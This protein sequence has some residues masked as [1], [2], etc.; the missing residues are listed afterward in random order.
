MQQH[1]H[2]PTIANII[3]PYP[4]LKTLP[5]WCGNNN[6]HKSNPDYHLENCCLTH[7]VG[8]PIHPYH[9]EMG[10][11]EYQIEFFNEFDQY[12]TEQK[13]QGKARLIHLNKGRQMGFTELVLRIIQ[14]YCFHDYAGK[15]IGIQAGTNGALARF[16]L[17]RFTKLFENIPETLTRKLRGN[18]LEL[19]NGTTITAY[20]ASE[21]A[22]TGF[23]NFG[24]LFMDEAAKWSIVDDYKVFDSVLPFVNNNRADLFMISTPKGPQKKFYEIYKEPGDFKKF[25][26]NLWR[27]EGSMYTKAEI[28]H[29]ID[30]CKE[31]PNQEYLCKFSIGKDSIFGIMDKHLTDTEEIV[32]YPE[33]ES[34]LIE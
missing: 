27:A 11:P 5:F 8:L 28:Q 18:T 4:E 9:G 19:Q 2:K 10:M 33:I 30:T 15:H 13:K 32:F 26:Y 22:L 3:E 21:E 24:A 25:E 23:T 12:K 7:K 14:Y 34:P 31:D 1:G 20:S 16:N 29:L 6:L 17:H